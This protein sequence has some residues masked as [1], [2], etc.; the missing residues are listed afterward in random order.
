MNYKLIQHMILNPKRGEAIFGGYSCG[1]VRYSMQFF[2]PA[3]E[4]ALLTLSGKSLNQTSSDSGAGGLDCLWR[5]FYSLMKA[6]VVKPLLHQVRAY[7]YLSYEQR[8]IAC[9]LKKRKA[10]VTLAVNKVLMT[11]GYEP[12]R[13]IRFLGIKVEKIAYCRRKRYFQFKFWL[14]YGPD[15]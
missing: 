2:M 12:E 1:V 8:P 7:E 13:L 4:Y 15:N 9:R 6:F 14:R 5:S 11:P 3:D 10:N